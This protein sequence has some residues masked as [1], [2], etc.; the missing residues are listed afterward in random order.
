M[1]YTIIDSLSA[2]KVFVISAILISA[3]LLLFSV[4]NTVQASSCAEV[5]FERD[6]GYFCT[7]AHNTCI[8][9]TPCPPIS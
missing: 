3:L 9:V 1:Y 8:V 6:M 2:K 5:T 4:E 7:N